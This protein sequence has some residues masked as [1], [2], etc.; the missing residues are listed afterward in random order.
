MVKLKQLPHSLHNCDSFLEE[1]KAS[2]INTLCQ[3]FWLAFPFKG[4]QL[5]L[6]GS[7]CKYFKSIRIYLVFFSVRFNMCFHF[8]Y[9]F[10]LWFSFV[11]LFYLVLNFIQSHD[12][13][14]W[15]LLLTLKARKCTSGTLHSCTL[16]KTFTVK[17]VKVS[18]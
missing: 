17:K 9:C 3:Y 14:F 4:E 6:K 1:L 10:K 18:S 15:I 11:F 2:R 5:S 8:F 7:N 16:Q 13:L 12:L